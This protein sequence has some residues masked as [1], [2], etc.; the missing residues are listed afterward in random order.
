MCASNTLPPSPLAEFTIQLS[1][2]QVQQETSGTVLRGHDDVADPISSYGRYLR[3]PESLDVNRTRW[4]LAVDYVERMLTGGGQ[5]AAAP[6]S[7]AST[8]GCTSEQRAIRIMVDGSAQ[9]RC[10][11]RRQRAGLWALWGLGAVC[12]GGFV[13]AVRSWAHQDG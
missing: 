3:R 7:E 8:I 6:P 2:E 1:G 11:W 9:L 4:R 12:L 5:W 13:I 10:A